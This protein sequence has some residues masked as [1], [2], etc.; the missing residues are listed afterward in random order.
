MYYTA[1]QNSHEITIRL[2]R[3][4]DSERLERLAQLDSAD[5]PRGEVLVA[6]VGDRIRA[7]VAI[8]DGRVIA[9]PFHPTAELAA[10]LSE[11][12]EQL[13]TPKGRGLRSKLAGR[14]GGRSR[15]HRRGSISPQ[16]AGTLRAFE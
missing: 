16:P 10:L 12:A 14:I 3:A 8:R 4:G 6:L 11:R 9:D 7:A 1:A 2:A 13:G 5:L 15:A